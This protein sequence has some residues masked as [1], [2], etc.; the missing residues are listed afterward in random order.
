MTRRFQDIW[1]EQC[2]AAR[3]IGTEH[4]LGASLDYLIGE[5]LDHYVQAAATRP[6]FARELPSFVAEVRSIF[7]REDIA[8]YFAILDAD[9]TVPNEGRGAKALEES[10]LLMTT[11]DREA[12]LTRLATLRVMLVE[13]RL[14]TG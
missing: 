10:G 2:E 6:E 9:A 5:K 13:E 4:G 14:G 11:A 7:R 1:R 3:R 12:R 8:R